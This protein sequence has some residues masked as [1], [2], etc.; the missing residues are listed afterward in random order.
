MAAVAWTVIPYVGI[1]DACSKKNINKYSSPR[2][3]PPAPLRHFP[4]L[5]LGSGLALYGLETDPNPPGPLIGSGQFRQ[6]CHPAMTLVYP[7]RSLPRCNTRGSNPRAL[8][9]LT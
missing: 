7:E 5:T 9:W 2:K 8:V 6:C 1:M 3:D 4:D